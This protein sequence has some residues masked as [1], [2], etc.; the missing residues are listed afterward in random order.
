MSAARPL[1]ALTV[2]A[3][4]NVVLH[5]AGLAFT[6]AWVRPGTPLAPL[7]ERLAYLAGTP[8]GWSL[9]WA[10]WMLCAVALVTFLAAAAQRLGESAALAPLGV[11]VAA[12]GAGFDLCCDSV[13][14]LVFPR[15]AAWQ[16]LQEPLFLIL[17]R[18]TGIVSLVIANGAY[19]VAAL[20]LTLDLRGRPGLVPL[21]VAAGYGVFGFGLLAAAAGFTG[22]PWHAAGA[23]VPTIGLFCVWVVL[24]ARSLQPGRA[25]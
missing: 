5:L 16:S 10:T 13:Y 9:G 12:V 19:S 2:L 1:C 18:I 14:I 6:A 7:A 4:T 24:V 8:P 11:T 20:L 3:W 22:V 21:T 17:E 15:L 23:T 25:P